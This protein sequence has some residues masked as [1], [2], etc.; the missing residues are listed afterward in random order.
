L[1]QAQRVCDR[2][3]LLHQGQLVLGGTLGDLQQKT[4]RQDLV[5]IFVDII[6]G[7]FVSAETSTS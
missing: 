3:G 7:K 2:F 4:G 1:E 5:E 6:E